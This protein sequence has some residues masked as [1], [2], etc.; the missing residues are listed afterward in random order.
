MKTRSLKTAVAFY[1]R[2][3]RRLGLAPES[4]GALLENLVRHAEHLYHRGPLTA[5]LAL[6][7][8][9]V[10]P[11]INSQRR[12][13]RLEVVRHFALFW[14]AFEPRT[15]IPPAGLFGPAYRRI[16]VHIYRPG[17]IAALLK[18]AQQVLPQGSLHPLTFSTLLGLLACTGLRISEALHLELSDWEPLGA[19]LTIGQAKFGQSRYVPLAPS[20]ATALKSYLQARAKA[21]PKS[22]A[23]ALFLNQRGQALTDRQAGGIFTRLRQR[24]N[25]QLRQPRPR[26]HDLRYHSE[27]RIIPSCQ[28]GSGKILRFSARFELFDSE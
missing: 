28:Q 18:A 24:L 3:R 20:A 16:P 6:S 13:R 15:Q 10:S 5:E 1:L 11:P 27:C 21:F 8:A 22:S 23:S 25:W 26:L 4:E 19:V 2:S 14:A 7:W 12:A 9:Q 17:E